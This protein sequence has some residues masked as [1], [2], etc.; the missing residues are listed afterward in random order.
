MKTEP[1]PYRYER[2][3]IIAGCLALVTLTTAVIYALHSTP[4]TMV[5]FLGVG[6][7]LL[8]VA[9]ALFGWIL[10]KEV[11]ARLKSIKTQQ[12]A[13]GAIIY[14]QG[15]PAEHVFVI[16]KGHVEA[17]YSDAAKGEVIVGR[18]GPDEYFG[19]SAILS[20]LPRQVTARAVDAV[21]LLVI[22]R[23]DFL[24]LYA[25]LP[26]LRARIEALQTPRAAL[27]NQA[28]TTNS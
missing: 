27:V 21:E 9:V 6:A 8:A 22:H 13:P 3:L 12:F 11:R 7:G 18:L 24:S 20:R 2:H 10:W 26:R 5:L 4:Y 1:L 28:K 23:N 25:S 15:D 17:I 16:S 14:R 19:E